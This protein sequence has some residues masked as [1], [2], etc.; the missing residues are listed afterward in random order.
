M[1][2][3]LEDAGVDEGECLSEIL[4]IENGAAAGKVKLDGRMMQWGRSTQEGTIYRARWTRANLTYFFATSEKPEGTQVD[5]VTVRTIIQGL[6][7]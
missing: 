5:M 1:R 6:C 4:G 3:T 7:R 2:G